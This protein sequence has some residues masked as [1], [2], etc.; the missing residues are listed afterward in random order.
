MVVIPRPYVR[1]T[2]FRGGGGGGAPERR[3]GG[4]RIAPPLGPGWRE[5]VG[6]AAVKVVVAHNRYRE[7]MPS[8]E[9]VIVDTEIVQLTEAGLEVIPFQRSSDSIGA[10]PLGQKVLLPLSPIY[11]RAAQQDLSALL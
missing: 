11:G 9:N 2:Q 4:G 3:G 7:A 5:P 10:L 6:S 8:G 1:P